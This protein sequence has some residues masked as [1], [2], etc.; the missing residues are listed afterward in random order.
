MACTKIIKRLPLQ[1]KSHK[2]PLTM[3][4]LPVK[5]SPYYLGSTCLYMVYLKIQ[6]YHPKVLNLYKKIKI[7]IESLPIGNVSPALSTAWG[8]DDGSLVI[9]SCLGTPTLPAILNWLIKRTRTVPWEWTTI[10][11]KS[12]KTYKI[13]STTTYSVN[14]RWY[15]APPS[16][17]LSKKKWFDWQ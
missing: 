6:H 2:Q 5:H 4:I 14:F 11:M 9:T 15:S 3:K 7:K 16:A 17:R 1:N 8:I 12:S 10:T 13:Y